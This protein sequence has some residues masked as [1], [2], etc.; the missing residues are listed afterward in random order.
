MYL[1]RSGSSATESSLRE[2]SKP[3]I[4]ETRLIDD[5]EVNC[6]SIRGKSKAPS[7]VTDL[8]EI[9]RVEE[10][11]STFE[12]QSL[13]AVALIAVA[14][15]VVAVTFGTGFHALEPS[16]IERGFGLRVTANSVAT[17]QVKGAQTRGIASNSRDQK[18]LLPANGEFSDLDIEVNEDWLRQLAGKAT[19]AGF[20]TTMAGSDSL[21]ITVPNFS[22]RGIVAKVEEVLA[23]YAGQAYKK[24]YPFL[25]QIIPIDRR[26]PMVD[27]LDSA[28]AG[29]LRSKDSSLSFAA[30]DPF[31][32]NS[33]DH[34]EVTFGRSGRFAFD[35][36]DS[37]SVFSVIDVL[38]DTKDPL[39]DVMVFPMDA[40]G[41]LADSVLPLRSYVQCEVKVDGAEYL[42]SAGLWFEIKSD[43]VA[44]VN[45]QISQIPDI[46]ADL[47]LPVWDA[48]ALKQNKKD[49]PEGRYNTA[50]SKSRGYALLDKELVYFGQYQKLEICDLLTPNAEL[51]CVKAASSSPT[52]SHLVAQAVDSAAAWGDPKYQ[53]MLS[54][55]WSTVNPGVTAELD[56]AGTTFVLAIATPKPG[57]LSSSLFFFTKVQLAN[58][59]R[60]VTRA[61][62]KVALARIEMKPI[63]VVKVPRKPRAGKAVA[64]KPLPTFKPVSDGSTSSQTGASNIK[65]VA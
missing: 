37:E 11:M 46:T 44:R 15:R 21:R 10:E 55:A 31:E 58:C 63:D 38:D 7:W 23:V 6:Y 18:T 27:I 60:L 42:L 8:G 9:A 54:H 29:K 25:D 35:D 59:L 24:T 16:Q 4:L 1:L 17:D 13:G 36:L 56:R 53:S 52:L 43:F 2:K 64:K 30:P 34:Y 50:L 39:Q 28:V 45:A 33:L 40:D 12:S 61:G 57:L 26:D 51:L 5:I 19:D 49:S 3:K 48:A 22:L 20:A 65:A 41:A 62:F 32:Q 14:D 47:D